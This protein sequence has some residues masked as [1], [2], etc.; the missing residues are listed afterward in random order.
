MSILFDKKELYITAKTLA[1]NPLSVFGAIIVMAFVATAVSSVVGGNSIVPYPPNQ[2]ELSQAYQPPSIAHL[3]GTDQL[4][5]DILSRIIAGSSLDLFIAVFVVGIS[6]VIGISVGSW[7][8]YYGGLMDE[9]L[10]RVT[11]VFISFPTVVLALAFS[12]ALG[13]GILHVTEA[14]TIVWWPVYARTARAQTLSVKQNQYFEAGR[15]AGRSNV[16]I[17]RTHVL[18]NIISP[19]LV[20]GALDLGFVILNA[21]VLSYLGL[22]AQPPTAEWGR[23]VYDGQSY[24]SSAWWVPIIPGLV[25]LIVVIGFSLFGDALRDAL[26]PKVRR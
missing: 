5:R 25:I 11:D 23:M 7:A 10:M 4:G 6:V 26:D 3:F 14:L 2:I 19:L 8:G 15:A 18:P 12:M 20:Y 13:P 1:R 16:A 9:A 24:I 17:I 22:G 21:S